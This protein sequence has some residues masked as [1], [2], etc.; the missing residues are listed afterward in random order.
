MGYLLLLESC[1]L[2][3]PSHIGGVGEVIMEIQKRLS[4]ISKQKI[5]NSPRELL[6]LAASGR[7]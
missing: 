7:F 1:Y 2:H 5:T 3:S 6:S 4:T